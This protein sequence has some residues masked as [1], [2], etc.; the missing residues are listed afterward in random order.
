MLPR[1]FWMGLGGNDAIR[2]EGGNDILY[3][4]EGDD[5]LGQRSYELGD[6]L[7]YGGAG[8]DSLFGAVPAT[9]SCSAMR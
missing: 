8:K 6:D 2:G 7:L 4:G 5:V 3:G 1:M 9:T